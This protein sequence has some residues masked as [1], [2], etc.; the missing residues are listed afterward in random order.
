MTEKDKYQ[1]LLEEL[2]GPIK[3]LVTTLTKKS[4]LLAN[5][6]KSIIG[7]EDSDEK[8]PTVKAVYEF[9]HDSI[10]NISFDKF[11]TTD[12]KVTKLDK[13]STNEQ[14][15]TAKAVYDLNSNLFEQGKN[16]FN[17]LFEP[18]RANDSPNA[19]PENE[20]RSEW[21][22]VEQGETYT[23]SHSK[24]HYSFMICGKSEDGTLTIIYDGKV[25]A[26]GYTFTIPEGVTHIRFSAYNTVLDS[27]NIQFEK[28][29]EATAYEP[30]R[31]TIKKDLLPTDGSA[32][33]SG[34]VETTDN[35]VTTINE[36]S[37]N[38]QYPSAKAV[39]DF[40]G[41]NQGNGGSAEN[42]AFQV[43][44][45]GKNL[46]N[47][48]TDTVGYNLTETGEL[49]SA[50]N[51]EVTD[52]IP[53]VENES[54]H[55][56]KNSVGASARTICFYDTHK[57]VL[58]FA[59][60]TVAGQKFIAPEN[61]KYVRFSFAKSATE[62]Q[63]EQS[64]VVT[65]YEAFVGKEQ[66]GY[67]ELYIPKRA[68]PS[69]ALKCM[70]K[71]AG[72]K[73]LLDRT[74]SEVG[75][76]ILATGELSSNSSAETSDFIPVAFGDNLYISGTPDEGYTTILV[77]YAIYDENKQVIKFVDKAG[78]YGENP[79]PL[80]R[81]ARFVRY[82]YRKAGTN[83]QIERGTEA[84]E[85]EEYIGVPVLDNELIGVKMPNDLPYSLNPWSG[86]RLVV[87]G[88]SITHD[89]GN[90]NYWQFVAAKLT[91]M[92]VDNSDKTTEYANGWK[93]VGGSRIANDPVESTDDPKYSIVL[94]YQNLPDDADLVI[95]AGGTNDWQHGNVELGEFDST[96]IHT[97]NGALNELLLGLKLKYKYIPIVM[98]TPIKR[99]SAYNQ[100]NKKG[101][102]QEQFVDAMIA[103]CKQYGI[104]CFDMYSN[105][106]LNPQIPEL[107]ELFF[108]PSKNSDG[109]IKY[110]EDGNIMYDATHPNTEG[111]K[112]MGRTVAG[113]IRTLS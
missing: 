91:D 45:T 80:P 46:L 44:P 8:Y 94:R 5:K 39:Y 74:V 78:N 28:G 51:Y 65:E 37:T 99:G 72:G 22:A 40:V 11:E 38:E 84:T 89:Q 64:K 7:N 85:Y 1:L 107:N 13:K 105:C 19:N 106:P 58:S 31:F 109:S 97:F 55:L 101:L 48:E 95:I 81:H 70:T 67:N 16:L 43:L 83:I 17:G 96:D 32:E 92:Y 82:S 33:I 47:R 42:S 24:I 15:P 110:D 41:N 61:A 63:F 10:N 59:S 36:N 98:M 90:Y 102:Y 20:S 73:N 54:Y 29:S 113:F 49:V 76:V 77:A 93:G 50:S 2:I 69:E 71:K 88:D 6:V 87:D 112:I 108:L 21:I 18:G 23:F 57:K 26:E 9:I 104:Y 30:Y 100:P 35:K 56:S 60:N 62:V 53:V 66:I 79:L 68:I 52:F 86:K 3:G 12:N 34:N 111:H 4:E 25:Y 14:Y 75:K 27:N 103:K